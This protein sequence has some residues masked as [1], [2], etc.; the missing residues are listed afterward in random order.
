MPIVVTSFKLYNFT[1][2][3]LL[4]DKNLTHFLSNDIEFYIK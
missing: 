3:V 4:I 1:K 2:Y